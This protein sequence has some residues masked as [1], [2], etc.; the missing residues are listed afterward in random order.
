[1]SPSW[2]FSLLLPGL[3]NTKDSSTKWESGRDVGRTRSETVEDFHVVGW[4]YEHSSVHLCNID[5]K[6]RN[7]LMDR[8]HLKYL[9]KWWCT[10]PKSFQKLILI[11]REEEEVRE[12]EKEKIERSSYQEGRERVY[13]K[14]R[15][16]DGSRDWGRYTDRNREMKRKREGQRDRETERDR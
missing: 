6:L 15:E 5:L 10:H 16:R 13:L 11:Q 8:K 2:W 7:C 1:M 14:E 4:Q 3:T 9:T 12:K